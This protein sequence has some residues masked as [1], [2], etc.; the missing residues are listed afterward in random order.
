MGN[1]ENEVMKFHVEAVKMKERKEGKKV[2]FCQ[3]S[4]ALL[5]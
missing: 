4:F 2:L 1:R 3:A 5:R